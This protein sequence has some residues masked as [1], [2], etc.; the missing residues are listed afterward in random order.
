MRK[1]RIFTTILL[2][3]VAGI[4]LQAQV[5]GYGTGLLP[6][7]S[8]SSG[9]NYLDDTRGRVIS[10]ASVSPTSADLLL[11]TTFGGFSIGDMAILIQMKGI[12]IGTHQ[13]V[14]IDSWSINGF[15]VSAVFGSILPYSTGPND[16]LQLV[17]IN[18]Y[19]DF[20]LSGGVVTCH[21]WDGETGG[22][23]CMTVLN[24]LTVH[25]GVFSVGG[26]GFTPG[27]AGV[28]YGT[29]GSGG[30]IPLVN[31]FGGS[32]PPPTFGRVFNTT[33]QT[34]PYA[35]IGEK[36]GNGST[37]SLGTS[38]AGTPVYYGGSFFNTQL[39]MGDPGYYT[40]NSGGGMGAGAGGP[41]GKGGDN[42]N[43]GTIGNPG[44]PGTAGG[45]G[46]DAGEGGRGG[47]VMVIKAT[48]V[49]INT[50]NVV[51]MC[52]GESGIFGGNGS[53]GGFGGT[54]GGGGAACC[55]ITAI[56]GGPGGNGNDGPGGAGGD[57]GEGG[58]PGYIWIGA[59]TYT[60]TAPL[61]RDNYSAKGG[62]AGHGGEGGYGLG[63]ATQSTGEI[64]NCNG[65][66]CP[67]IGPCNHACDP[68][69]AMCMLASA[70]RAVRNGQD[71]EFYD[72]SSTLCA[73][74]F[75]ATDLLEGYDGCHIYYAQWR[76]GAPIDPDLMFEHFITIG[77]TFP[78]FY[79]QVDYN[80]IPVQT[81]GCGSVITF[82]VEISFYDNTGQVVLQYKHP[83]KNAAAYIHETGTANRCYAKACQNVGSGPVQGSSGTSA[84]DVQDGTI[85]TGNPAD[86]V[87]IDVGSGW[88]IANPESATET[89]ADEL[90]LRASPNPVSD[91]LQVSFDGNEG[92]QYVLTLYDVSGRLVLRKDIT[93]QAGRNTHT[94]QADELQNG[95][96]F[97]TVES[98]G[99]TSRVKVVI[100]K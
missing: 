22:V 62:G 60:F 54:G 43:C 46:G 71:I 25:G 15:R 93:G 69:K 70:S 6:D 20:T 55:P 23:L 32:K 47:G 87:V 34:V 9:V 5:S 41:G 13:N 1:T 39:I 67:I 19:V 83:S 33:C 77:M 29:G 66:Y 24:T 40:F 26:K 61:R 63:N 28:T 2:S 35:S 98:G 100:E 85:D 59:N 97:V 86:N 96:Y 36:G 81:T 75:G 16:R 88:R 74:Y 64:V 56:P 27:K 89:A 8:W 58:K 37:G 79:G 49:F 45:P 90:N 38:N 11:S 94:I 52:F 17:K 95:V 51:F 91:L 73:K 92:G 68:D 10:V 50:P 42:P 12:G 31:D 53:D 30:S 7:P 99:K 3:L 82:P 78:A 44:Y 4:C 80:T 18:E 84:G 76:D 48:D 65:V 72:I 21:E 57:G 14:R